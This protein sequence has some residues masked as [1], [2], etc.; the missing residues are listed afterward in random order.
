MEPNVD[1]E[2]P[3]ALL[4]KALVDDHRIPQDRMVSI[5]R[6]R[7][8]CGKQNC[9]TCRE[10]SGHGPYAFAAWKDDANA[11]Q[12]VQLSQT[13]SPVVRVRIT[14]EYSKCGKPTCSV[15]R[16]GPGH[17]PYRWLRWR[18]RGKQHKNYLGIVPSAL[19]S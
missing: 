16:Y 2:T 13:N 11:W 1:V 4:L 14:I 9:T 15:C 6:Y 10:G 7:Q 12:R 18:E 19:S 5:F 17:G 3:L 8:K